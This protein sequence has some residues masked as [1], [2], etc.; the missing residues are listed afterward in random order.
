[1]STLDYEKQLSIHW[2][3]WVNFISGVFMKKSING[4]KSCFHFCLW[5]NFEHPGKFAKKLKSGIFIFCK[6][7]FIYGFFRQKFDSISIQ[8]LKI[9]LGSFQTK[10]LWLDLARCLL[11]QSGRL[12]TWLYSTFFYAVKMQND[13]FISFYFSL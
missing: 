9:N 11:V 3:H 1:M 5:C 7:K 10:S 4:L 6:K 12:P 8:F 2:I 13:C